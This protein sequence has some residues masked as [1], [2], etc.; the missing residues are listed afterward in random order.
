MI[1]A[2][3]EIAKDPLTG[4]KTEQT[5]YKATVSVPSHIVGTGQDYPAHGVLCL[6]AG[7]DQSDLEPVAYPIDKTASDK[8]GGLVETYKPAVLSYTMGNGS[9]PDQEWDQNIAQ[10]DPAA[11]NSNYALVGIRNAGCFMSKTL[12][13]AYAQN[14]YLSSEC[15]PSPSPSPSP[16]KEGWNCNTNLPEQNVPG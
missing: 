4:E 1:K 8:A 7:C 6:T 15:N 14:T 3:T 9:A 12:L 16:E 10:G 13:P 11:P 2:V 5:N